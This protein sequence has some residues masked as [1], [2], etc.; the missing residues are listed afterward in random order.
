[1]TH[2]K[3][4]ILDA[5]LPH[6]PFDGW[7]EATFRAAVGESGTTPAEARAAF[8]RGAVDLAVH[9]HQRGDEEMRRRLAEADLSEMRF[10]DRVAQAVRTR[11]EIASP[12]KEAVRR[13]M[14]LFSLPMHA[15]DGTKALW[16]TADAIWTALGDR[17]DDVNWYT[18][19]MTLSGVY[20]S[21]VLYWLGDESEG[22]RET[23]GFLD[24]RIEDVMRI[25]KVKAAVNRSP[26]LSRLMA[27]PNMLL[28]RVRPPMR[29]PK[30]LPGLWQP[31][32]P[33]PP[34]H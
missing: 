24:R 9:F 11:I 21:T 17:S 5:A 10:R 1:M 13:G 16:G 34:E 25:E 19:R 2:V 7:S 15:A 30:D 20:S 27:G 12:N 31:P 6:V 28:S 18:K 8:P 3:D 33:K 26:F 22:S 29:P 23:W 14:A 32:P 4:R